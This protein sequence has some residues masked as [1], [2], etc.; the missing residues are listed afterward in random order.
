MDKEGFAIVSTFKR[1]PC[2][3]WGGVAVHCDH[4]NL[5]YIFVRT[6]RPYPRRWHCVYKDGACFSD[7]PRTLSC[8]FL[9]MKTAGRPAVTL[10]DAAGVS[11]LRA[12][13][14]QVHGGV[15]R[16]ERQISDEGGCLEFL[17]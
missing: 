9:A 7:S 8:T 2:L 16:W 14:R 13:E 17:R 12:R 4:R 15:F 5:A 1:L 6:E 11:G 3:L 10:D